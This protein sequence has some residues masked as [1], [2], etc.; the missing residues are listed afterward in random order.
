M[1]TLFI[2]L[3]IAGGIL[4]VRSS[5][6]EAQPARQR[7]CFVDEAKKDPELV[8][9]RD[10]LLRAVRSRDVRRL[11][12]FV[13]PDV[14]VD[15]GVSGMDAFLKNYEFNDRRSLYWKDLEDLLLLGGKFEGRGDVF[16]APYTGCPFPPHFGHDY[17]V[18]LGEKVPAY[19]KPSEKSE[20]LEWLSCDVLKA[21]GDDLPPPPPRSGFWFT[22]WLPTSRW[23]FVDGRRVR[24]PTEL[25][26][27]LAK[28]QGKWQLVMLAAAD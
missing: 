22:V 7:E 26:V 19:A 25:A 28:R 18:V 11:L 1:R 17:V 15:I 13:A 9:F 14:S 8:R 6:Q 3:C 16:C 23:A 27:H 21:S 20:V 12:P 10:Q 2:A 4:A 5:A 24:G